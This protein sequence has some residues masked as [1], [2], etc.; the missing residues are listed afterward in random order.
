MAHCPA[1]QAYETAVMAR[2][3]GEDLAPGLSPCKQYV[4]SDTMRDW[5]VRQMQGEVSRQVAG[6]GLDRMAVVTSRQRADQKE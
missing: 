2:K 4:M 5:A 3:A 1:C 6:A